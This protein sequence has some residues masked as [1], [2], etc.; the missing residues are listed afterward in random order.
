MKTEQKKLKTL[1]TG[2]GGLDSRSLENIFKKCRKDP[3]KMKKLIRAF[4]TTY[5]IDG[6]QRPLQLRP[7]QEDIIVECLM[8]RNDDKQTK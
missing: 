5:L 6:K 2:K 8:E 1:L 7:M 3:V 4:C